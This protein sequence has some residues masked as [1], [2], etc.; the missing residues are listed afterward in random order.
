MIKVKNAEELMDY[1][2]RLHRLLESVHDQ[3]L[4][5]DYQSAVELRYLESK[6]REKI[7]D[8]ED[9]LKIVLQLNSG[10]IVV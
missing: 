2:D 7:R 5:N 10:K 6:I 9:Q 4:G 8:T 3:I 1:I